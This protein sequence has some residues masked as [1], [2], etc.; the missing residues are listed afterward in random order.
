MDIIRANVAFTENV[1]TPFAAARYYAD[2]DAFLSVFRTSIYIALTMVSDAFIV[3]N[4][5]STD[6]ELTAATPGLSLFL[7]L[8]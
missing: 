8:G 2:F 6:H 7:G 3:R 1:S 4:G 5:E